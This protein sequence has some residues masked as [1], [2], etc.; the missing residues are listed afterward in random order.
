MSQRL[1]V[2]VTTLMLLTGLLWQRSMRTHYAYTK[3]ELDKEK[4]RLSKQ[5]KTLEM[6]IQKLAIWHNHYWSNYE[7]FGF[8]S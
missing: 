8:S 6:E 5:V 1:F 3:S 7:V 4:I 2:V